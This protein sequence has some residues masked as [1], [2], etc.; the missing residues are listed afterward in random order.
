MDDKILVILDMALEIEKESIFRYLDV[1]RKTKDT[2]GKNMFITLAT[3]EV[4]HLLYIS[5]IREMAKKETHLKSIQ[6]PKSEVAGVL[7][8]VLKREKKKHGKSELSEIDAL[9]IALEHEK[10]AMEFYEKKSMEVSDQTLKDLFNKLYQM[11]KGHYE[12]IMA[13]LDYIRG[14]GFWFDIPEFSME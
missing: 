12:L 10:K 2:S 13:Q 3:E 6:V 9:E 5:E 4:N 1:A 11:E 14:T 8:D 7:P